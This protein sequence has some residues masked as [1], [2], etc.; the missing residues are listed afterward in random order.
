MIY[1]AE[2]VSYFIYL[3]NRLDPWSKTRHWINLHQNILKIAICK[4]STRKQDEQ[5]CAWT[6]KLGSIQKAILHLVKS[7]SMPS[8]CGSCI[9][10]DILNT[11][12]Y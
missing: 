9:H 8:P 3:F 4:L 2:N 7:G 10:T 5:R 1:Y 11:P 12:S 6:D